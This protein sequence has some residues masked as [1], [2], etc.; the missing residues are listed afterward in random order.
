MT[1]IIKVDN[2]HNSSGTSALSFD[3]SGYVTQSNPIIF[4]VSKGNGNFTSADTPI[5]FNVVDIDTVSAW[6]SSTY[7]Y[8]IPVSGWYYIYC[9]GLSS[10]TNTQIR[11]S[12]DIN[13]VPHKKTQSNYLNSQSGDYESAGLFFT[14]NFT[15]GDT[16]HVELEEGGWYGGEDEF[17]TFGG[18]R[19]A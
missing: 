19:I 16:V 4:E 1:S 2:I 6:N 9:Y 18:Y 15:V 14:Y 11:Y 5:T 13:D 8:V 17:N 3:S 12:V 10:G 7:K